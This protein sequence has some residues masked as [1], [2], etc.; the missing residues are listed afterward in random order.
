MSTNNPPAP[1]G[2]EQKAGAV[3]AVIALALAEQFTAPGRHDR[4]AAERLDSGM[5]VVFTAAD[6]GT[7]TRPVTPREAA[8]VAAET[9]LPLAR[10]NAAVHRA[11]AED[12]RRELEEA[13]ARAERAEVALE[14]GRREI[15]L[16]DTGIR[17]R[18][19]L[20]AIRRALSGS[21]PAAEDR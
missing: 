9:V 14:R 17:P 8:A 21:T 6:G 11:D 18:P 4:P 3:E 1:Q 7:A 20:D 10:T 16:W 5:R 2:R 12:L 19:D 15:D 13:L